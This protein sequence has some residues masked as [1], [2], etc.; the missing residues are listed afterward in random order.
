MPQ[1]EFIEH[2]EDLELA[3]VKSRFLASI[4]DGAIIFLVIAITYLVG[5]NNLK[6]EIEISS[7]V[8]ILYVLLILS[9]HF[10]INYKFL[11]SGQTIGKKI[12]KI[13]VLNSSGDIASFT[14]SV[15]RGLIFTSIWYIPTVGV[16]I[17]FSSILLV[18]TKKRLCLHD[19]F[20]KTKVMK[21]KMK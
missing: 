12:L 14:S 13:Q 17:G 1:E 16:A 9:I 21:K 7:T 15:L 3:S 8:H 5:G 11:V 20:A 18:F 4:I 10:I 2:I 6:E 19:M